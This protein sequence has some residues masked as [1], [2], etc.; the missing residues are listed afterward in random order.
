MA[1]MRTAVKNYFQ[2][3]HAEVVRLCAHLRETPSAEGLHHLRVQL[4]RIRFLRKLM[5]HYGPPQSARLFLPYV[6][7]FNGAGKI[8][9]HQVNRYRMQGTAAP[10]DAREKKL[11]RIF[12]K[13]LP[14]SKQQLVLAAPHIAHQWSSVK[15]PGVA[16]YGNRLAARIKKRI[17]PLLFTHQLH[18]SRKL[19]KE[20]I[21]SAEVSN[22]LHTCLHTRFNM[23]AAAE[24][25]D[26]IGDWHDLALALRTRVASNA[27]RE[28][29]VAQK[30]AKLDQV[31]QLL[32][33][34]LFVQ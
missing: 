31:Y 32:R 9:G 30:K 11:L 14:R 5:K 12:L 19:L 2:H 7:L 20:L 18:R 24:L 22:A 16:A 23:Q 28:K 8:R 17:T 4:K 3:V 29:R 21:Y 1:L 27:I 34:G 33:A 10:P 25:E 6:Q 15:L 13:Q 26:K